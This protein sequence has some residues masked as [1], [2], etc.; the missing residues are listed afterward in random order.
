MSKSQSFVVPQES[1]QLVLDRQ[2]F[3]FDLLESDS[4]V[5]RSA[6][7][8]F[9]SVQFGLVPFPSSSVPE[10]SGRTVAGLALDR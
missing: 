2:A 3:G 9:A 10:V 4:S 5:D 7:D 8:Q 6:F 1:D